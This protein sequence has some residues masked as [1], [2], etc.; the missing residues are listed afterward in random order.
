[1]ATQAAKAA[2]R[3]L[4]AIAQMKGGMS[5][6]MWQDPYLLGFMNFTASFYAKAETNNKIDAA[7]LGYALIEAFENASNM[8]GTA[9]AEKMTGFMD[10]KDPNFL[11]SMQDATTIA[12]YNAGSITDEDIDPLVVEANKGAE[13][14]MNNFG[15]D[16]LSA[17]SANMIQL[18]YAWPLREIRKEEHA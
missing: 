13:I 11:R 1:M 5:Y 15:G 9:I 3:P 6:W 10:Q 18:T 17:V 12:L 8:N 14:I 7:G 16:R 2:L 4:L